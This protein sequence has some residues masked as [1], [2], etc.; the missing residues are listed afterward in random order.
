MLELR[1]MGCS[2]AAVDDGSVKSVL[3]AIAKTLGYIKLNC[4]VTG[5]NLTLDGK[6][7][8]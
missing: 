8:V 7:T 3:P 5:G 4:G 6:H 1:T 2:V